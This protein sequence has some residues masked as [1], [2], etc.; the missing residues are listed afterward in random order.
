MRSVV[1]AL[2]FFP[3]VSRSVKGVGREYYDIV[4]GDPSP[5]L[6]LPPAGAKITTSPEPFG[7][8]ASPAAKPPDQR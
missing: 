8:K 1:P 2:N 6:F 7:P 3:V 5:G 4:P